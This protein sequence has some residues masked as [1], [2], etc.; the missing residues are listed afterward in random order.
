MS[1]KLFQPRRSWR[2][3]T[4]VLIGV[5]VV[6]VAHVTHWLVN[7]R[8][9]AGIGPV[10]AMDLGKYG[11]INVGLIVF[12][13]SILAT[14]VFGR[15]F[16]GWGCHLMA[17]Q[18]LCQW[19]LLKVGIRP[20][21]LRSRMLRL[22][23]F[24]AFGYMFLWPAA[25][26]WA[27]GDAFG[28]FKTVWSTTNLWVGLPGW[29]I[30]ILTLLSCGFLIVYVLGSRGFCTYACPYGAI[31]GL[32]EWLAPLRVRATD[33]CRSCARCTANCSSN[34][35]VHE[36]VRDFGMVR[37]SRCMKC[38]DCV[39]G[40][41]N[42][43]LYL[44]YGRPSILA[45]PLVA[46]QVTPRRWNPSWPE[47]VFLGALFL[48]AF[49]TLRGL[50]GHVPFLMSLG[51]SG[52]LAA[53]G[54]VTVRLMTRDDLSLVGRRLRRDGR[55]TRAGWIF[56]GSMTVILALWAHSAV[57]RANEAVG[58]HFYRRTTPLRAATLEL[59]RPLFLAGGEDREH[60]HRAIVAL[61]RADAWGFAANPRTPLKLAWMHLLAGEAA[62][63]AFWVAEA[64]L[65]QPNAAEVH[66][67]TAREAVAARRYPEAVTAY[68]Y[69]I[70]C[71][72]T[73]PVGYLSLGNV[74][75]GLGDLNG[76]AEVFEQGIVVLP[77]SADLHYNLGVAHALR[78]DPAGAASSFQTA[79]DINPDHQ[80]ARDNLAAVL[81]RG[82]NQ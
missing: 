81:I 18:D 59:N 19:L 63:F 61:E 8:T 13:V 64:S 67:L 38:L 72:P 48:A 26:R 80:Q 46:G 58:D 36:H 14:A 32:A 47:E 31:F 82:R 1:K 71:A 12:A 41:P 23:P 39:G 76:A 35:R 77:G 78:G 30:G 74:F 57:V 70:E 34:I 54:L 62:D 11:I 27:T 73:D 49:A 15:F 40:C 60:V 16:C 43:A 29:T 55:L 56:G 22:V 33:G 3:R 24:I 75:A 10:E 20:R 66:L 28:G 52:I 69:A 68:S 6:I 4:A 50:Y 42:G 2:W 51:V 17:L 21:P 53:L 79:L 25:Y 44:G 9:L 65:H 7:G 5:H 45:R 37:D